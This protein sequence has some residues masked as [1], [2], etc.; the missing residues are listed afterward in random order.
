MFKLVSTRDNNEK[1]TFKQAIINGLSPNKGLYVPSN[2]HELTL[3]LKK[4]QHMNYLEMAKYLFSIFV[5]DYSEAEIN[6]CI[7]LAYSNSFTTKDVVKVS[8]CGNLKL[9]ELYHGPTS[10]FKDVALQLLP[11]LL[12][13]AIKQQQQ[14]VM[15]LT[16][17]SGDTG[18][19]ALEGFKDILNIDIT[20]FYPYQKVSMIQDLQMRTTTGHNTHVASVNTD[21]DGCQ[22]LCKQVFNNQDFNQKVADKNYILSSANSINIG[23]LTPQIVYYFYTYFKLLN[24]QEIQTD[25][26]ID[27]VVP[28]GNFG[29]VLAGYYAKLLGLPINKL[30]VA[31][32]E[33]KILCDFIQTGIYDAQRELITTISPS[34]D[35]LVSSNVERL[36]YDLYDNNAKEVKKL[37]TDLETKRRYQISKQAL[38]KLQA[39]FAVGYCSNEDSKQTIKA[40]YEKTHKVLDP[41]TACGYKVYQDY[42][43]NTSSQTKTVLLQTA[44]CYKFANDVY[45]ALT[46][47]KASDE[48][49]AMEAIFKLCQEPIPANLAQLSQLT[50]KHDTNIDP[51]AVYTYIGGLLNV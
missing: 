12:T 51:K 15:I 2:I 13:T 18:K 39:N 32:N 27:F 14:K 6:Q 16:A 3:D 26:K 46:S 49:M 21:F 11:Q 43:K 50:I 8:D 24:N 1:V 40:V 30:I 7:D 41:H 47:Q 33:N 36:L 10:A 9:L 29:D 25:E 22:A 34:M 31:T 23:R 38:A 28:T 19:A 4:M 48:F 17:T 35:I 44:S 45:Q 20:V 42:Q 37:M 5:D